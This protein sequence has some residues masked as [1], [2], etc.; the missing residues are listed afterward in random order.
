MA[1]EGEGRGVGKLILLG[2]HAVVHGVPALAVALDRGAEARATLLEGPG[3]SE[4]IID[5][6][7]A[8][9]DDDGELAQAFAALLAATETTQR[10]RVVGR[11]HLRPS[12][13]L[14][15]SAALG[16][17]ITRA[18]LALQGLEEGPESV[19]A[20]ALAWEAIFHG[21]PS[22]ID[23][24][25]AARGGCL[26]FQRRDGAPLVESV[27]VGTKLTLAIGYSGIPASTRTMVEAVARLREQKP[28]TVQKTFAGIDALVRNARLAIEAG[29][30]VGLGRLLDF[31]QM[32]L[33]GLLVS[34]EEIEALCRLAREAGALG[35]KL[36]G[37]GGGGCVL[38]LTDGSP[39]PIL[40][41]WAREGFE[42]F[43][44]T[45]GPDSYVKEQ[46]R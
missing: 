28:E 4:L 1:V 21:N 5:E 29:D 16:V 30:V 43:A 18:L 26:L 15:C 8:R 38:A 27:A 37:A 45:I 10:V 39:E 9:A 12:A 20:R 23:T 17:A 40:E 44:A 24:A 2:E 3:P 34:T 31:G 33:S 46:V 7:S 19:A 6:W 32:L 14:G 25:I 36:T 13:G 41:A 22:G 11:K 35:A 42:G